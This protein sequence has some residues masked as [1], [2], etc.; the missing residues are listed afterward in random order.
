M[1]H[2]QSQRPDPEAVRT[3]LRN[4]VL[5]GGSVLLDSMG[6]EELA[7]AQE[8]IFRDEAEIV[9]SACKPFLIAKLNRFII[10]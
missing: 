7:V 4:R 3:E 2:G 5:G 8:M 10:S 9:L 1:T 6:A